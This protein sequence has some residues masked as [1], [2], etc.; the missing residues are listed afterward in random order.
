MLSFARFRVLTFDCYGTLINWEQG[1]L[2]ALRPLLAAHHCSLPDDDILAR[3]ARLETAAETGPY[4]PYREVL[5]HVVDGLAAQLQF[6]PTPHERDSLAA[7]LAHWPPFPDTVAALRTLKKH[8]KLAIISNIDDDLFAHSAR[9][10]QVAFDWVIT[11]QQAQSYKPS[12]RHFTLALERL[13]LPKEHILHVAQSLYHDI[14]PATQLGLATVWV[15]RRHG[16]TGAGAT[17]AAQA[18]PDLE[19]PDL[20]TLVSLMGHSDVRM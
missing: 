19:V 20:R 5:A 6:T 9:H 7:S 18:A 17:P 4:R 1:I 3:F 15:N 14:I 11:A 2:A 12:P 16:Q 8:Y 13:A 10:L